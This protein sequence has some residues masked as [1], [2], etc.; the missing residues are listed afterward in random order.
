LAKAS[1]LS[2]FLLYIV[3]RSLQ[4]RTEEITEQQI[5]VHVFGR[6]TNYNP[7][8][9]NIVRQTARQLRQRLALYYQEEGRNEPIQVFV[10]RG[11]YTPQF[12]SSTEQTAPI[13]SLNAAP[14]SE[15]TCAADVKGQREGLLPIAAGERQNQTLNPAILVGLGVVLGLIVALLVNY[16]RDRLLSPAPRETSFGM[17]CLRRASVL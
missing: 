11:G 14:S 10:P 17:C 6:P 13:E 4:G 7:G 12:Q 5:G 3:E 16:G 1:R 2:S 15:S 9:D 8:D